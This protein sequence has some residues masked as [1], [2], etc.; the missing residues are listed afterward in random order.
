MAGC[1]CTQSGCEC[2]VRAGAGIIVTGT[3]SA[4][5]PFVISSD[6]VVDSLSVMDTPSLDLNM[7][8]GVISGAVRLGTL[9]RVADTANLD[10]T[11]TG[12]GTDASPFI[13]SGALKGLDVVSGSPGQVMTKQSD[14]TWRA[15]AAISA[16]VG[17][18]STAAGASGDGSA[19]NPI[20]LNLGTYAEMEANLP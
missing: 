20:R 11:L 1:N 8:N 14:G 12:A 6:S 10:L 2:S 16:P 18:I 13:L 4:S 15:A 3:G 7:T 9:L 17:A 5:N 19:G